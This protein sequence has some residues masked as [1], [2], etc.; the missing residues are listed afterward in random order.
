MGRAPGQVL[1]PRPQTGDALPPPPGALPPARPLQGE[2]GRL[3]APRAQGRGEDRA[4]RRLVA[5]QGEAAPRGPILGARR[6]LGGVRVQ[7]PRSG[8]VPDRLRLPPFWPPPL[9]PE[10]SPKPPH[11][12]LGA[13]ERA[14]RQAEHRA[15]VQGLDRGGGGAGPG[16]QQGGREQV[17]RRRACCRACG[18]GNERRRAFAVDLAPSHG[19][20]WGRGANGRALR[21]PLEA[22]RGGA[23]VPRGSGLPRHHGVPARQARR[24][25]PRGG[26]RA[27]L[28]ETPRLQRHAQRP[29]P[30]RSAALPVRARR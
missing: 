18:R 4:P 1:G 13:R 24:V 6:A 22:A 3:R 27:P 15:P 20:R 12:R 8:A 21:P 2:P 5:P 11:R 30:R 28:Q 9:R 16:H 29:P 23:G 7:Q 25:G 19:G 17:K 14:P 10:G 26:R